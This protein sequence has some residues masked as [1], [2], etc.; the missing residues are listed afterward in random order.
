MH[1]LNERSLGN[2]LEKIKHLTFSFM[3]Y[4]FFWTNLKRHIKD[5]VSLYLLMNILY[6]NWAVSPFNDDKLKVPRVHLFLFW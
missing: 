3:K 1:P 4:I 2:A 6:I 5:I